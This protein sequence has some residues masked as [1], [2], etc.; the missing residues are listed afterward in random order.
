MEMRLDGDVSGR[1]QRKGRKGRTRRN[2]SEEQ[3][4]NLD[5]FLIPV[6]SIHKEDAKQ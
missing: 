3:M 1:R 4:A 6:S 5:G 2:S